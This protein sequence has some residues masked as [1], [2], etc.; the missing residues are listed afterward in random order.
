MAFKIRMKGGRKWLLPQA[1]LQYLPAFPLTWGCHCCSQSPDVSADVAEPFRAFHKSGMF[2]SASVQPGFTKGG[3]KKWSPSAPHPLYPA[4]SERFLPFQGQ[5]LPQHPPRTLSFSASLSHL[6]DYE[7]K[8]SFGFLN[9]MVKVTSPTEM[10]FGTGIEPTKARSFAR[11][12][13]SHQL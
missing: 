12:F 11:G 8:L 10:C 7:L 9:T 13:R 5:L 4:P 2:L 3:R 6:L 1:Y